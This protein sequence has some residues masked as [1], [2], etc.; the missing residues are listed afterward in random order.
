MS[1]HDASLPDA[2]ACVDPLCDEL[3]QLSPA[4]AFDIGMEIMRLRWWL[5]YSRRH[6][7]AFWWRTEADNLERT[8]RMLEADRVFFEVHPEDANGFPILVCPGRRD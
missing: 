4:R 6:K 5:S 7:T 8:R 2:T 1:L 3:E